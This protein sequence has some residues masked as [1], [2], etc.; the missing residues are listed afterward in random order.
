[1]NRFLLG[2]LMTLVCLSCS[3]E[4]RDTYR[5]MKAF[6]QS[7][8]VLPSDL[9]KICEGKCEFNY[10]FD[11]SFFYVVYHG[12]E[13][14]SQ[15]EISHLYEMLP[16]FDLSADYPKMEV[17]IVFSPSAEEMTSV[18]SS[19]VESRFE[20]PVFV[21]VTGVF[22]TMEIPQ[23]RKYHHFLLNDKNHPIIVGNVLA[24]EKLMK[25]L[26]NKISTY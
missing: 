24:S 15:C 1:M 25:M 13:E 20:H 6:V 19:L 22:Q 12:P 8:I 11:H 18:V 21:D 26:L 4:D 23:E 17:V 5:V 10:L 3:Q 7:E 2:F 9:M 16:L 14:C